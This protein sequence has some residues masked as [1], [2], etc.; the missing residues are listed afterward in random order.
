MRRLLHGFVLLGG[1]ALLVALAACASAP[2]AAPT[3]TLGLVAILP[4][5]RATEMSDG[6]EETAVSPTLTHTPTPDHSPTPG[7]S[8]TP[9]ATLRATQTETA[10]PTASPTSLPQTEPTLDPTI[11]VGTLREGEPTPSTPIPTAVPTFEVPRGITNILLL[12]SDN[13]IGDEIS[14]RTDTMIIV[15]INPAGPT[16][17]MISLPRDLYV[18]VPGYTMNRINTVLARGDT[19]GYEGGGI[20]LLKQTILYN[21]G[22]PIHYYAQVDFQGF[23]DIVDAIGGVTLAVSCERSD[24]RLISPELDPFDEENWEVYTL[25]VGIHKMDGDLALWY[26][27]SRLLDPLSD[28]SRNR[29]QQQLLRAMFNQGVDLNL[30]AEFP[31]LWNTY[32]NSVETDLD[33]GRMLQLASLAPAVRQNGIQN[34]YLAGKTESWVTPGGGAVQ[35]PV[36]EGQGMM[37]D[38]FRRLFRPP[39]LSRANRAP[40]YVEVINA[41]DRPE[42]GLLAADNLAW[43][44]FVPIIGPAEPQEGSTTTLSY[45]KPNFKESYD[46]LISWIFNVPR[47]S[48]ELASD[49]EY[50]YDYR[51]VIGEDYNPCRPQLYAP[52]AFLGE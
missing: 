10:V 30:V 3:P 42:M 34:L 25:P 20:G 24:W 33:I 21:F 50:T 43:Y 13:P 7:P 14:G 27:R 52:Q 23:Q 6:V 46:W 38:T 31:T 45:Y 32:K 1:L 18:Y 51:V 19:I 28:W 12:G 40:I 4:T 49:S 2:P 26:A 17:S 47:G 9:S 39:D 8:P 11:A 36:W 22:V 35:L 41:T 48:I 44:G 29:R 5:E 15:S 37:R 16:A